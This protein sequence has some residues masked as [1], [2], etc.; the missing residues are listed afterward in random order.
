MSIDSEFLG[1]ILKDTYQIDSFLG[2]GGPS[3][4]YKGTDL[5]L[6][7]PV[8]IKRLKHPSTDPNDTT[9][10]RFL[11]EARTQSKL[12]HQNIVGIRSLISENNEYY[13]VM[14]FVDG[15]DLACLLQSDQIPSHQLPFSLAAELFPT[16]SRRPR[17]RPRARRNPP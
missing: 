10:Q 4:V 17:L 3:V 6:Q 14:E 16:S 11:R 1:R 13:I 15:Q 5:L 2:Q 9:A 7:T 8:A 12:V